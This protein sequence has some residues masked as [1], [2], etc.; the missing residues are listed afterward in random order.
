LN[1][2]PRQLNPYLYR[3]VQL[4]VSFYKASQRVFSTIVIAPIFDL[5]SANPAAQIMKT[6][7][8][9]YGVEIGGGGGL[10]QHYNEVVCDN[11]QKEDN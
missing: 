8:R 11:H 6:S 4:S 1:G 9:K 10:G 2:I 5:C 7:A 3:L